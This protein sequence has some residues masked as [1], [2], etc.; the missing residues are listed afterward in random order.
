MQTPSVVSLVADT[1]FELQR[2]LFEQTGGVRQ[3]IR[4]YAISNGQVTA[5]HEL[6]FKGDLRDARAH[7]IPRLLDRCAAVA[8]VFEVES[9]AVNPDGGAYVGEKRE[10]VL[11]EITTEL[12]VWFM[13]CPA[14]RNP[15]R[16]ERGEVRLPQR[17]E[18]RMVQGG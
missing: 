4:G 10:G 8:C 17:V 16:L 11:I 12:G 15:D 3:A 6:D 5:V 1:E 13:L 9:R 14:H 2:L 7:N 18:G